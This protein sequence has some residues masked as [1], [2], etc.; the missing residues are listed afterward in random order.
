M[1]NNIFRGKVKDA[2]FAQVLA[3]VS[4]VLVDIRGSEIDRVST[5][6]NG[7]WAISAPITGAS[8]QFSKPGFISKSIPITETTD[9][10]RL[11]EDRLIGYQ[12]KLWFLPGEK[13]SVYVHSSAVYSATLY[14]HGIKKQQLY[15]SRDNQE[16][17]QNVPDEFFTEDGL[18]W[19]QSFMY[20][21]PDD[22]TPG[23][24]SLLLE[25]KD[26][27]PFAIPMIVS[28]P[29]SRMGVNK[30]L[31]L[32][33]TN[34]WQAYN[35]WGGRSR[36]LNF[37][38][39][40]LSEPTEKPTLQRFISSI[41]TIIKSVFPFSVIVLLRKYL[42]TNK[43]KIAPW[44]F[45]K[46]AIQ[47]PFTNCDL[48]SD[49]WDAPFTNHLAGAEW[50]ILAWLEKKGFDYDIVSGWELDSNPELLKQYKVSLLSTHC[51]YWSCNSFKSLKKFHE[52]NGLW[53]L[54]LSGNTMYRQIENFA[55]GSLRCVSAYFQE[56]CY[57]ESQLTGVR[58]TDYD[59]GTCAAFKIIDNKHWIFSNIDAI[60]KGHIF[61]KESLNRSTP[62]EKRLADPGRPSQGGGL[63]GMG[64]S[65]WETDKQSKTAS[66]MFKVV[67][68]GMNAYGGADI[69]VKDPRKNAGGVLSVPSI[70][71][72]GSL[73]IDP[74]CSAMVETVLNRAIQTS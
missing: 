36:Y 56:T 37:E 70:V 22:A 43:E 46:L 11:L 42:H 4:V 39:D 33:S 60:N 13:V 50:R 58:F 71:F 29:V 67:A 35:I 15:E 48:E 68:K 7:E 31:V 57:D 65:G 32:A 27:K 59:Y 24:Y 51:E 72:G 10:I 17:I 69:V 45:K 6:S 5:N 64:A 23:L 73:A 25:A 55:D 44:M 14:R 49:T 20:Q 19:N 40:S 54:N 26:Q 1:S 74:V 62:G 12:D 28:T 53:V 61:G 38:D 30:L 8:L 18:N 34:T 21:I 16:Q 3:D 66:K 47:R 9:V 63:T 52:N 41:I 2:E